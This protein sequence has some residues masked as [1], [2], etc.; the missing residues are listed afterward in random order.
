MVI[1]LPYY[2]RSVQGVIWDFKTYCTL[3]KIK[4]RIKICPEFEKE[5]SGKG[6]CVRFVY[7][8]NKALIDMSDNP[9]PYDFYNQYNIVF[10][11]SFSKNVN[12]PPN[13]FPFGL[14]C[15]VF[16]GLWDVFYSNKILFL[17]DKRNRKELIRT[18]INLLGF[19]HLGFSNLSRSWKKLNQ[20]EKLGDLFKKKVLFSTR[21][22]DNKAT[23]LKISA[24]RQLIYK[25]LKT[26]D[27]MVLNTIFPLKQSMYLKKLKDCNIVVINNGLHDVP[28]VRLSELLLN[29]KI[30]LTTDLN[31]KIPGIDVYNCIVEYSLENLNKTIDSL[32]ELK[33]REI[34]KNTSMFCEQYLAPGKRF[35]YMINLINQQH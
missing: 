31:V 8:G 14:R 34:M 23:G 7:E 22:W 3:K 16:D 33:V 35:E 13:V 21:L 15:D 10:K 9:V 17:T 29:G 20:K 28:G 30:V 26:R 5:I 4:Y 11:R 18:I 27:D 12:Y 6:G 32:D 2:S 1:E 24:E 19:D 25:I